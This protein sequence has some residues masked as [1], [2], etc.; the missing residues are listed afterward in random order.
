MGGPWNKRKKIK[1]M[2]VKKTKK[3]NSKPAKKG[4]RKRQ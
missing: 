3:R 4:R 1:R 2:P